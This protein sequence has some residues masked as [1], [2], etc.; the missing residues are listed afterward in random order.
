MMVR[1]RL[2][3][4]TFE[5]TLLVALVLLCNHISI[6]ETSKLD[7]NTN[8]PHIGNVEIGN[9]NQ[10][11]RH[12][13]HHHQKIGNHDDNDHFDYELEGGASSHN[14]E[15]NKNNGSKR[16]LLTDLFF[17][18]LIKKTTLEPVDKP[19]G[20]STSRPSQVEPHLQPEPDPDEDYGG[21]S[22]GAPSTT[23]K[24][25]QIT[26]ITTNK[27]ED[28][29]QIAGGNLTKEEQAKDD[30]ETSTIP[31]DSLGYLDH[32]SMDPESASSID[33]L[34]MEG[35]PATRRN[36]RSKATLRK[37][38]ASTKRPGYSETSK[39]RG[40]TKK[41]RFDTK[42]GDKC[43]ACTKKQLDQEDKMEKK[44]KQRR[45]RRRLLIKT[46]REWIR[47]MRSS[48]PAPSINITISPA[49]NAAAYPIVLPNNQTVTTWVTCPTLA[50]N[51]PPPAPIVVLPTAQPGAQPPPRPEPQV[52]G[53]P[54]PQRPGEPAYTTM[55]P[56]EQASTT[57]G[58][59]VNVEPEPAGT[60][61]PPEDE[62]PTDGPS[63]KPGIPLEPEK[64]WKRPRSSDHS[65]LDEPSY[66]DYAEDGNEM[67]RVTNNRGHSG[68]K[69]QHRHQHH[70]ID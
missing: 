35:V 56:M 23:R 29:S 4:P 66:F 70:S 14:G 38:K 61:T 62:E 32:T 67:G 19:D 55:R 57:E 20:Q 18:D 7:D 9:D 22:S 40:S 48:T 60:E 27:P 58:P 69:N 34:V 17:P 24:P 10:H 30:E 39:S 50:P 36:D 63:A 46:I 25:N 68:H 42:K 33:Y 51:Q 59:A 47:Y 3:Q 8:D 15:E 5:T 45:R 12:Q 41:P 13:A 44:R 52:P 31:Q 1:F 11:H 21:D 28:I 6:K 26:T 53:E 65:H 49:P 64:K 54:G 16:G 43:K 2:K 37:K